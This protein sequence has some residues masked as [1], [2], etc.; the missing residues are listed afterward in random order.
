[1]FAVATPYIPILSSAAPVVVP[2][3]KPRHIGVVYWE[4]TPC[5]L[6][7]NHFSNV[8]ITDITAVVLFQ[9]YKLRLGILSLIFFG[10]MIEIYIVYVDS[11]FSLIVKNLIQITILKL[12][13]YKNYIIWRLII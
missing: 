3:F 12:Y 11:T 6:G 1:M 10:S 9:N 7:M 13:S 2:V 8:N 5:G 4:Y